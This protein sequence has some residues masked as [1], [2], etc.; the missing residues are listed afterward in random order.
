MVNT[1]F[2]S[3][4]GTLNLTKII[5]GDGDRN[6]QITLSDNYGGQNMGI[7]NRMIDIARADFP[8]VELGPDTVNAVCLAGPR[9]KGMWGIEFRV[10]A[11]IEAPDAYQESQGELLLAGGI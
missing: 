5:W 4:G 1:V 11:G 7:L 2:G 10:P 8:T 9:R 6:A 3:T